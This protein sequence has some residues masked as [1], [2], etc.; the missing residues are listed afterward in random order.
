[1]N[2]TDHGRETVVIVTTIVTIVP[3]IMKTTGPKGRE[4]IG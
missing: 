3:V 1:M 4:F 2:R